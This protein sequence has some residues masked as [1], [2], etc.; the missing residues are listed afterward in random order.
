MRGLLIAALFAAGACATEAPTEVST[1][2]SEA[3]TC[4]G[5]S[6]PKEGLWATFAVAGEKFDQQI[7][8]AAGIAGALALWQGTSNATIPVGNLKCA[9]IGWNCHWNFYMEPKSVQ[10]AESTIEL[11][12]GTP[13]Y[14]SANCNT[15]G[16]GVYCPWGAQLIGLRDCRTNPACPAVPH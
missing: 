10:F 15:F 2:E 4:I 14:V 1:A 12:D 16:N 13:S 6:L 11:C 9:C 7:T 8:G 3:S 5:C